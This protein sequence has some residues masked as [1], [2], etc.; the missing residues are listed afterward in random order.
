MSNLRLSGR[1]LPTRLGVGRAHAP[2]PH[3]RAPGRP[4]GVRSARARTRTPARTRPATARAARGDAA[5][6]PDPRRALTMF[7]AM[8]ASYGDGGRYRR[9][10]G[11]TGWSYTK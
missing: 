6:T 10:L 11:A 2:Q 1:G 9:I 7:Y 8:D 5:A 3:A 4:G